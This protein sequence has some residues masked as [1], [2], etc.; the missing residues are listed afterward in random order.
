MI[1][2]DGSKPPFAR[3]EDFDNV[4]GGFTAKLNEMGVAAQRALRGETIS[5]NKDNYEA[6]ITAA[7]G[8]LMNKKPSLILSVLPFSDADYYNCIK[9]ACD[10]TYGVRNINVLA[11]KFR[12]ANPQY[13]AN[14]GLKVNLK[15]GGANQLLDAKEL[16]LI[17]QNKTMLVGMDVT[18]PSPGPL[19]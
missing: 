11:D 8:R 12:D 16:G 7:V 14:V 13:F 9:R 19:A 10:L 18:H 17:G 1:N 2:A 4:L 5:V 6:G 3:Q 15:L